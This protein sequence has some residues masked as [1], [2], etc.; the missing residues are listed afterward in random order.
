MAVT[1][2]GLPGRLFSCVELTEM[3]FPAAADFKAI[4]VTAD[5]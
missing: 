2:V 5:L 4:F 1:G 3:H